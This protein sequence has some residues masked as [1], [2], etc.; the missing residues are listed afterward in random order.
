MIVGKSAPIPEQLVSKLSTGVKEM[1]LQLLSSKQIT[2]ETVT[3]IIEILKMNNAKITSIHTPLQNID[4]CIRGV[5]LKELFINNEFLLPEILL[6]AKRIIDERVAKDNKIHIVVHMD[7]NEDEVSKYSLVERIGVTLN[8]F[9]FIEIDIEHCSYVT[10]LNE[11]KSVPM[12]E[13]LDLIYEVRRRFYTTRCNF[14]FDWCHYQI[15]QY[16]DFQPPSIKEIESEYLSVTKRIHMSWANGDGIGVNHGNVIPNFQTYCELRDLF[17]NVEIVAEV[18]EDDHLQPKNL[19]HMIEMEE[20]HKYLLMR[21]KMV[22]N[23]I[24]NNK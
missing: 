6:L 3:E 10:I 13:V 16:F 1:E 14:L 19:S 4:G 11:G 8:L 5:N 18:M 12:K 2:N 15:D 24:S 20:S 9:P 23:R 21:E 17:R 22:V 7:D